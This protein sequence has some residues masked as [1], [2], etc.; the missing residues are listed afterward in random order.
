MSAP[1]TVTI[2]RSRFDASTLDVAVGTT[3]RFV[4][5][6]PFDH[7]VT[8]IDGSPVTFDSGV[9]VEGAEFEITF[10]RPGTYGYFCEIHPTMRGT[11]VVG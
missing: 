1:A 3:V 8:S 10:D 5:E 4:N 11:V 7:T 2:E 9:M 6:D